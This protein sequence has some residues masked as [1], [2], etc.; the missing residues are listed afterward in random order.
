MA[1]KPASGGW[2]TKEKF[3]AIPSGK[4]F[5]LTDIDFWAQHEGELADWCVKNRC[6]FAGM[7][8]QAPSKE[9]YFLFILRWS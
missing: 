1:L 3:I 4:M 2:I 8:V 6:L 5:F 7:T 9:V